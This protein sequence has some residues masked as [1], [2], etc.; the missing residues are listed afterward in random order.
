MS[1]MIRIVGIAILLAALL[2]AAQSAYAKDN[3]KGF[4][5]GRVV[6]ESGSEYTGF[7]RWGDQEAFWDD[8]FQSGKEYME[9]VDYLDDDDRRD[10]RRRSKKRFSFFKKWNFTIQDDDWGGTRMFISRFGDIAEIEPKGEGDAVIH[11]KNGREYDVS[12]VADDVTSKIHVTDESLGK[13]EL[14]WDRI[15]TVEFMPAP[16]GADPG[17]RRLYGKVE[18]E[19]GGFEGY[20]QWDKH[21]CLDLDLLDGD[22]EDG[23]VSIQFGRIR[24]IERQGRRGSNVELKDGR[25]MRL[26][27]S[28]DVNSENRG[29]MVE[30]PRYGR[31]TVGWSS[32][33][34]VTFSDPP[35]SGVGYKEYPGRGPLTG[36]VTDDRGREYTGRI[37]ID[38]DESEGW[39][40]LNGDMEDIKF[41]IPFCR[42]E[43]LEPRGEDEC[44]VVLTNGEK[45][46]LEEGQDV[47]DRNAGVLI[48]TDEDKDP[49]YIEWDDV[50]RIVFKH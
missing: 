6:T 10:I 37:V 42:I 33:E 9:F 26:H 7:L 38:L 24:S 20:I 29:V 15:E 2:L 46:T 12:G 5:Y 3:N 27:G 44:L 16:S 1:R 28:N 34:R 32:F 14:R 48:F 30:D 40:M 4:I 21:E 19:L 25:S 31:V 50:A 49:V 18:T 17:V 8:L 36:T 23:D 45:L 41:D 13:M 39:E 11:M 35:G 22:T 47:S 43:S